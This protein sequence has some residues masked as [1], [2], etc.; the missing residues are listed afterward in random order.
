MKWNDCNLIVF[1]LLMGGISAG[2]LEGML[3]F[4]GKFFLGTDGRLQW[5]TLFSGFGAL[6]AAYFTIR[7]LGEQIHQTQKLADD[8]RRRRARA[9][10]ATL[11]LALSQLAQYSITCIQEL[12]HLRRYFRADGSLGQEVEEIAAW[13]LPP[14]SDNILTSLKECI[15]FVDDESAQAITI[16]I[17]HLQIQRSRV[18]EYISR[19]HINDEM[20]VL[21]WSNIEQDMWDSAEV[22]A[23]TSTLFP[24]ARGRPSCSY[25]VT[26]SRVWEALSFAGCFDDETYIDLLADKWQRETLA[27]EELE[28]RQLA[29]VGTSRSLYHAP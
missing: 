20:R 11:P 24:F 8:Q 28:Q 27:Y 29:T 18:M 22:H 7:R 6:F 25:T 12:Y 26:R 5:E 2:V 4:D 17:S 15:E 13:S 9:A 21:K 23:R 10:R 3:P 19:A 14:L 1:G 16:L